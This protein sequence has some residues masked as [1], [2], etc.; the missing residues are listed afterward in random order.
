MKGTGTQTD[1]YLVDNI[2]DFRAACL[3]SRVYVK[4]MADLDCN[5]EGYHEWETLGV[6]C[7]EVDFNG[8]A[9]INPLVVSGGVMLNSSVDSLFKNGQILNIYENGAS[10]IS[11]RVTFVNMTVSAFLNKTTNTPF[12]SITAKK[13]N[14]VINNQNLNN[15]A[16]FTV[17]ESKNGVNSFKDCR[18]ELNGNIATESLF[19]TWKNSDITNLIADGCRFEGRVKADYGLASNP[20]LMNGR[21][22]NSVVALNTL[23]STGAGAITLANADNTNIY[24]SDISGLQNHGSAIPC[25]S[26]Q[27]LDPDYL[28]SIGFIVAEV[29]S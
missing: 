1:P 25:T 11:N 23:G 10:I 8:Y 6:I 18:F 26:E 16:W 21:I 3:S 28:N 27:I 17:A 24:Q 5:K 12:T 14:F 22:I 20:Y 29:T 19:N 13:C 2:A 9:L 4:L 15:K 7:Y